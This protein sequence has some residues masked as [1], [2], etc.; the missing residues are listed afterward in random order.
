MGNFCITIRCWHCDPA[1]VTVQNFP[2]YLPFPKTS[3]GDL[4]V[5]FSNLVAVA[6]LWR[7]ELMG[8]VPLAPIWRP[9]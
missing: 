8:T 9:N 3:P 4:C 7:P 6:S 5:F 2:C 1:Q